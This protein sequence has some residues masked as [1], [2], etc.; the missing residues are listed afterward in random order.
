MVRGDFHE[1][2]LLDVLQRL[3][4]GELDGRGQDDLLVGPGSAHVRELLGLADVDVQVP[5]AGVL[6]DDHAAVDFLAGLDEEAAAVQ[7]LVHRIGHGLARL[8]GDEGTVDAHLDV[9]LV[10][11]VVLEAVR[12]DGLALGGGQEVGTQAHQ[13]AGRDLELQERPVATR[14]HP[15][16]GGLAA[17]G[18]LDGRAHELLRNLD[19]EFLDRFAALATDGLVQHLGLAHL[20]L[21]ALPAHRFDEHGQVQDAAAVHH[22][23]IGIQAGLDAEG[24][25]LLELLLQTFLDVAGG[26]E[27]AVLAEERGV[28]DHEEHRHRGLVDGDRRERLRILDVGDGV[29]DL[30]PVDA[31]QGA[32]V[33]ALDLVHIGLAQALEHHHLLDLGLLDDVVALAQGHRHAGLQGSARDAS[34]GDPAHVRG[35][36]QGGHEHLRGAFHD[37]G[38]RDFLQDGVQEGGD[39]IGGLAPVL[40]HP[41]LLRGTVDGLEIQLVLGGAEV[42]HQFE[43]LFLHLVGPAVG[44]VHLVDDHD[45]LLAHVQGLVQHEPRLR[46]A[47]LERVHQQEDAVRHIE[48]ALHLAA[49]IAMAGSVD[50]IDLDALVRDGHILRENGDAA[51]ALQVVV[52]QDEV[53]QILG[54]ANE[55]GLIDHPVHERRLAV[56]D[57][58]DDSDVSD[59]LHITD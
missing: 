15:H 58:G 29:A 41:A 25:V 35:V 22:E 2:V 16:E 56:V 7:Q 49:E 31:H 26:H 55:I 33:A 37:G 53:P 11:L 52:V 47:A 21:E 57:V 43:H 36:F 5:F 54:T 30:E 23:G 17:G 3:L 51:L 19:G 32:D 40:G 6:A 42:E 28:V 59:V 46:H 44:L 45:G 20:Q 18:K 10:G 48:H 27:L 24:E 14:F 39:V 8:Q 4:Q 12:N 50:D 13:A 1:L 34:H 38:S 9:A